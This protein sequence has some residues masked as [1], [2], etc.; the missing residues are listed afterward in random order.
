MLVCC[1]MPPHH[2]TVPRCAMPLCCGTP[3]CCAIPPCCATSP[4]CA[5]ASCCDTPCHHAAILCHTTKLRHTTVL[6]HV[7]MSS[8]HDAVPCLSGG[9]LAARSHHEPLANC[10]TSKTCAPI[11]AVTGTL[12]ACCAGN[13][14]D[15]LHDAQVSRAEYTYIYSFENNTPKVC[16]LC[17]CITPQNTTRHMHEAHARGIP[18]P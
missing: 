2:H 11:L 14:T 16:P 4:C 5:T 1:A 6:C 18:T 12:S 9:A 15:T 17:G 13:G 7:A 10:F 8:C 3:S